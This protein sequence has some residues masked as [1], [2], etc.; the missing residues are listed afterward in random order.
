MSTALRRTMPALL[1]ATTVGLF[2]WTQDAGEKSEGQKQE[3][4]DEHA[5]HNHAAPAGPAVGKKAED[6]TTKTMSGEQIQLHK[7][8]KGKLV[9]IDFW[10]TWCPPCIREIPHLREANKKY[11]EKGLVIVGVTLDESKNVPADKVSA[12]TKKKEMPWAQVYDDGTEIA[13]A[14]EIQFIPTPFLI[15]G[16]TGKI[17][18]TKESLLGT[19]LDK[20]LNKHI[21]AKMK[22]VKAKGGTSTP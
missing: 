9:L 19:D 4:A 16:D 21:A 22:E 18:A 5:G 1:I 13:M 8:F 14:Y 17:I 7:D 11:A 2:A 20:T 10:A 12:F 15:D 6:F 3:K